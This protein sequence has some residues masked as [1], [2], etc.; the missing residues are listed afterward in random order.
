MI[1]QPWKIVFCRKWCSIAAKTEQRNRAPCNHHEDGTE[2]ALFPRCLSKTLVECLFL[3]FF[4]LS[5]SGRLED[6]S[7]S[8]FDDFRQMH[9]SKTRCCRHLFTIRVDLCPYRSRFLPVD[10]AVAAFPY[11]FGVRC[12]YF[13]EFLRARSF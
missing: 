7:T 5:S 11:F 4:R 10:A 8:H 1:E 6:R 13:G 9:C 2:P 3:P 12:P